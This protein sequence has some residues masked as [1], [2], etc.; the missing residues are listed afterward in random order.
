[1]VNYLKKSLNPTQQEQARAD[2]TKNSAGGFV[3]TIDPFEQLRRFCI[4]G[5]EGGTY[6]ATERKMAFASITCVE[7]CLSIDPER[8]V[9]EIEKISVEGRSM[10]QDA[11]LFAFAKCFASKNPKALALGYDA[12]LTICRTGSHILAFTSFVTELRGWG[13]GLRSAV[14]RWYGTRTRDANDLAFQMLKYRHREGW[15]HRDVLRMAH[16][17]TGNPVKGSLFSYATSGFQKEKAVADLQAV[18]TYLTASSCAT[19]KDAAAL[20][21]ST[22]RG[23][24]REF[25]QTEVVGTKEYWQAALSKGLPATALI[26]NLGVMG[27]YALLDI[28]SAGELSVVTALGNKDYLR[29]SGVHPLSIF[30]AMGVYRSGTGVKGGKT[31]TANPR[32]VEALDVAFT[33]TFTNVTPLGVRVTVAVD[34]SGSMHTGCIAGCGIITPA[35]AAAAIALFFN[36]T[37]KDVVTVGFDV[38]ESV[39]VADFTKRTSL[40][41][42]YSGFGRNPSGTDCAAPILWATKNKIPTDLFVV[43]TDNETWAGGTHPYKALEQYRKEMRI[44]ARLAACAMTAT[45]FSIA[46]PNDPRSINVV[47]FDGG[48][49]S[50]ISTLFPVEKESAA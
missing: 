11:V 50:V 14:A 42:A 22:K 27:S 9:R 8:T 7:K 39:T 23:I 24:P 18:Q 47:G 5:V 6:Y 32:I 37:E 40:M 1:M 15:H 45:E 41:Q 26:R 21:S 34:D 20:I 25:F 13:R 17:T 48:L 44:D 36:R 28:R 10:K 29:E 46:D 38:T 2:Q 35:Q 30:Q 16:P 43:I 49:M 3:F 4:L 33:D 19:G 12:I 31:W